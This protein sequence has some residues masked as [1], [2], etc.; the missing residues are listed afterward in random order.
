MRPRLFTA[1][2]VLLAFATFGAQPSAAENLPKR[3]PAPN[4]G[5]ICA[6]LSTPAGMDKYCVSS[7]FPSDPVVHRFK[8]GP[9]SLID[10][11][12]DTAWVEGVPGHGIG[13]WIVIEF[14]KLRLVKAIEINNGYNK[15]ADIF[16]K[17]NRVKELKVE[18]SE[19]M[20]N[21]FV[22]NDTGSAQAIMLPTQRPLMAYWIKFTI[23][24][25]YRGKKIEW[26]D[27]AISELHVVSEPVQ[28]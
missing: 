12:V 20:K 23:E 14:D 1:S 3:R 22:L 10:R 5:G 15:D 25:V 9:E 18:Y 24:S 8:Y 27:T 21:S 6:S 28:P 17:N 7:V 11:A 19:R 2:M 4:Q 26:E 13:Q 16:D